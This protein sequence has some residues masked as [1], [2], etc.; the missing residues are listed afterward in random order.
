MTEPRWKAGKAE[1][2]GWRWL[3]WALPASVTVHSI[4]LGGILWFL[5][6]HPA[7]LSVRVDPRGAGIP[8]EQSL[9]YIEVQPT[10][11]VQSTEQAAVWISDAASDTREDRESI[12]VPFLVSG[13]SL[14]D[15]I[16]AARE[17]LAR[18]SVLA[19]SSLDITDFPSPAPSIDRTA[20]R[21]AQTPPVGA[22]EAAA[23]PLPHPGNPA[24]I[25]P[26]ECRRKRQEGTV[27]LRVHVNTDGLVRSLVVEQSSG[28]VLLDQSALTA[29]ISWR[30]DPALQNGRAA[31]AEV[32]LPIRFS[33]RPLSPTSPIRQ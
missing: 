7:R 30:F 4:A 10:P 27:T 31:D 12:P 21:A 17:H 8:L 14:D 2:G 22:P 6:F 20:V 13:W 32:L 29:A 33:L 24:P 11:E 1:W 28:F 9:V 25:Y 16:A 19:R 26:E 15:S 23:G 5:W 3:L 18:R